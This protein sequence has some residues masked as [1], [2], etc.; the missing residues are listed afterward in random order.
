MGGE[1]VNST[2]ATSWG[3][4]YSVGGT[5]DDVDDG[6]CVEERVAGEYIPGLDVELEEALQVFG[7]LHAL[8]RLF[9]VD[10]RN[11]GRVR[12]GEPEN[13][14]DTRHR[15]CAEKAPIQRDHSGVEFDGHT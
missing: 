11:G 10:S 7:S 6:D 14:Q 15:V 2:F 8:L 12:Q 3:C 13:L 1:S 9:G 4:T 5:T